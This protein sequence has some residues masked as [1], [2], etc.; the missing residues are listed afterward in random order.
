M[1]ALVF[2]DSGNIINLYSEWEIVLWFYNSF[3]HSPR[4]INNLC[5]R[6]ID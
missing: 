6:W 1:F 3:K 5:I 2:S 4:P